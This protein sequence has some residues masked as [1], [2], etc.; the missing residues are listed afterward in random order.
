[1]VKYNIILNAFEHEKITP[2]QKFKNKVVAV[3]QKIDELDTI[4][5]G[6][7]VNWF[8]NMDFKDLKNYYKLLS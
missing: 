1:M 5:G 2:S 7:D 8:L 4:A 3:F 6:T